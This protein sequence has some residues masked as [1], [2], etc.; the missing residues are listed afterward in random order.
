[1]SK[2]APAEGT[3]GTTGTTPATSP[4]EL[5]DIFSDLFRLLTPERLL[6][7]PRATGV[8]VKVCVIDSGIEHAVLE[9]KHQLTK[10]GLAPIEGAV[11]RETPLEPLPYE[12][13]Q[14]SPHGTTVADILLTV[15][16]G[17]QL[18]SADVFGPKGW[19]DSR[20]L[21]RAIRHAIDIW[22]CKVL[23]LSL[24]MPEQHLQL[25][26]RRQELQRVIEEAYYRDVLVFAAASNEHPHSRS[27]P[28]AFA[29]PLLSVNKGLFSDPLEFAYHLHDQ[30]E[31]LA[32]GRG[33]LGP[34]AQELATSW[35]TPH[36]AALAA[37]LLSLRPSLK[38]FEIKTLFY[39]MFQ[40]QT[41]PSTTSLGD[42]GSDLK[43]SEQ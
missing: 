15:A 3:T 26:Q 2:E 30:V 20:V 31:F 29:P 14:S 25:W 43:H 11:F 23:N 1:M 37:R 32:Q 22:G 8:G 24:G 34:F 28:A 36:L 18:Y 35:A 7:H 10:K 6:R 40:G 12:G 42:A 39:W 21:I 13:R 4:E 19:C 9:E 5:P 16:P 33:Y 41:R 38:L 17:V 27:Y